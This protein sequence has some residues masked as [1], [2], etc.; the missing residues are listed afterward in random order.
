MNKN[1]T[2]EKNDEAINNSSKIVLEFING[3]I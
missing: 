2:M 3:L 1:M